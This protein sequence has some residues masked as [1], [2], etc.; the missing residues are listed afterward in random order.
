[1]C[2]CVCVCVCMCVYVYECV[3]VCVCGVVSS[4]R[5]S[6]Y[7][8]LLRICPSIHPNQSK[9][10]AITKQDSFSSHTYI[11]HINKT[12]PLSSRLSSS[13]SSS[14]PIAYGY[15]SPPSFPSFFLCLIFTQLLAKNF[16]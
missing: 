3:C 16:D 7:R 11:S 5:E 4:N 2:A 9:P 14:S 10:K 1:M 15:I 13:S 8:F 12:L 6:C